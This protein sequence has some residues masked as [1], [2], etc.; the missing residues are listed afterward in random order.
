MHTFQSIRQA[1]T[2]YYV[3]GLEIHCQLWNITKK[4]RNEKST[5]KFHQK[6]WTFVNIW[7]MEHEMNEVAAIRP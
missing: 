3:V 4:K 2:C 1:N 6:N 5:K 7:R